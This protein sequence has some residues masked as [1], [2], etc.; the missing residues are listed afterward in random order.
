MCVYLS[1]QSVTCTSC[2]DFFYLI[3]SLHPSTPFF[4]S[5]LSFL[6]FLSFFFDVTLQLH[7]HTM[8]IIQERPQLF[9]GGGEI[10]IM[11]RQLYLEDTCADLFSFLLEMARQI[12]IES[13]RHQK[14]NFF[15]FFS[16]VHFCF[17]NFSSGAKIQIANSELQTAKES[18]G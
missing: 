7:N 15:F 6:L 2:P 5:L 11:I 17:T 12:H 8:T 14:N 16:K 9:E 3:S 13:T 18:G 4:V 1:C 10:K